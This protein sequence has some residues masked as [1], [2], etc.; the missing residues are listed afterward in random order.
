MMMDEHLRSTSGRASS[1]TERELITAINQV[2]AHGSS[3][4]QIAD[5]I[6]AMRAE[7]REE[8]GKCT[9]QSEFD[10]LREQVDEL[11]IAAGAKSRDLN[12]MTVIGAGIVS[13][14]IWVL[15]WIANGGR[16]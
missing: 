5:D 4:R 13:A 16:P 3:I 7:L 9:P 2:E 15:Q 10:D 6:R 1:V 8:R 12:W 11:R 14:L